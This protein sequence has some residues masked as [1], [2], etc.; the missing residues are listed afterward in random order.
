MSLEERYSLRQTKSKAIIDEFY[1]WINS[2]KDKAC[3]KAM[4]ARQLLMP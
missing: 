2:V 3:H 4:W 1:S